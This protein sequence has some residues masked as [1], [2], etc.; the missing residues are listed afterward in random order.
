MNIFHISSTTFWSAYVV[1]NVLAVLSLIYS[2]HHPGLTRSFFILLFLSAAIVNIY[3]V[4]NSPLA[5]QD[6]ADSATPL[7]EQFILGA[8]KII[9]TPM[10]LCIAAGQLLIGL[11]M[12]L[13]GRAFQ[14]G[15]WAGIIFLVSISPLGWNAAFP[16]TLVMAAALFRLQ[17]YDG[18]AYLWN[19]GHITL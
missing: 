13:K 4:K 14:T 15:C 3:I 12:L 5:Y 7:Y 1:A 17:K 10:V 2:R 6:Y 16:S 11:S 19:Q 8:F 9:I 18:T